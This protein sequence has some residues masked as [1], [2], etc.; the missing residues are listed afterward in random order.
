MT[1]PPGTSDDDRVARF[2][3]PEFWHGHAG[4]PAR[5]LRPLPPGPPAPAWRTP[6]PRRPSRRESRRESRRRRRLAI[7]ITLLLLAMIAGL[8]AGLASSLA[9]LKHGPVAG[10]TRPS[11]QA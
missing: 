2:S 9:H 4:Y 11:W 3:D 1:G 5:A 10:G 7:L 6:A 8:A